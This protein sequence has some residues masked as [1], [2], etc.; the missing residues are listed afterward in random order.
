LTYFYSEG[1]VFVRTQDDRQRH[2]LARRLWRL[3]H[4]VENLGFVFGKMNQ[5]MGYM[6]Y[7]GLTEKIDLETIGEFDHVTEWKKDA[8]TADRGFASNLSDYLECAKILN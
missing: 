2:A 7:D 1:G 8:W 6:G 4:F 5:Q 3:D